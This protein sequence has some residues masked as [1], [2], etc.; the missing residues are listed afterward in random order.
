MHTFLDK[1]L[2]ILCLFCQSNINACEIRVFEC[3]QGNTVIARYKN[4]AMVFDAGSSERKQSTGVT[5][6]EWYN[7]RGEKTFQINYDK[8]QGTI[9]DAIW[10]EPITI[11]ISTDEY[12]QQADKARK[13]EIQKYIK[14][15]TVKTVWISHPDEDHYNLIEPYNIQSALYVLGG[16][17]ESYN[18]SFQVFV[19]NKIVINSKSIN[20]SPAYY[21][22]NYKKN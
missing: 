15:H 12:L 20:K 10:L 22:S 1:I 13:K 6:A 8:N 16:K 18:N 21:L 3:G 4:E 14:G 9:N 7:A 5:D 2:I 17:L 19:Q 11:E